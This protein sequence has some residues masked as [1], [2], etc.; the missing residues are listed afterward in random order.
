MENQTTLE[1]LFG[2]P[3]S[4]YTRAQA[5]EDGQLVD[6]SEAD[7]TRDAGFRYPIA[8]TRAI[9]AWVHPEPMPRC[10]DFSGRLWDLYTMFRHGMRRASGSTD[11][12]RFSVLFQGG[13]GLRGRQKRIVSMIAVCGPGDDAEPVITIMLPGED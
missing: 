4:V 2:P 10:Q 9:W 13:P 7:V 12:I 8:V 1:E 11:R 3:I 6:V 5:I